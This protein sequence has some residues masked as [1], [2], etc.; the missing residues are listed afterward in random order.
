M[1]AYQHSQHLLRE[2]TGLWLH[3]PGVVLAAAVAGAAVAACPGLV[4]FDSAPP[5]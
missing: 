2:L 1:R 4:A 3:Q 5:A